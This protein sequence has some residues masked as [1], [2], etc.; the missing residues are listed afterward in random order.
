MF[1]RSKKAGDHMESE[2]SRIL[3]QLQSYLVDQK[4][5]SV[6]RSVTWAFSLKRCFDRLEGEPVE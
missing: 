6:H 2:R 4:E 1:E 3:E 5:E